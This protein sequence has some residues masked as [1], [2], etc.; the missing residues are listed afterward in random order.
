M[1][2]LFFFLLSLP[3]MIALALGALVV[4]NAGVQ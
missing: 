2:R 1:I 3:L 4:L